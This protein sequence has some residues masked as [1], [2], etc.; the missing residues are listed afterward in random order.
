MS[1]LM[2]AT[3]AISV[4]DITVAGPVP[5]AMLEVERAAVTSIVAPSDTRTTEIRCGWPAETVEIVAFAPSKPL[6]VT[7]MS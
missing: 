5:S 3:P 7:L 6:A 1:R 2:L 4:D